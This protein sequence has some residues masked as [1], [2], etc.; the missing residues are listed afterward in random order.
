MRG[1]QSA[2]LW[3][4]Y[5][6]GAEGI[7]TGLVGS[8]DAQYSRPPYHTALGGCAREEGVVHLH[9]GVMSILLYLFDSCGTF[10]V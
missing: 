4:L 8:W 10:Y 5:D 3:I 6:C 2:V 1:L 7:C 9:F